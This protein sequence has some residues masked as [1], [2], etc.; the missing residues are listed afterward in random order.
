MS[1]YDINALNCGIYF[2]QI[3]NETIEL[4]EMGLIKLCREGSVKLGLY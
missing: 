3:R 2:L 1:C 4:L